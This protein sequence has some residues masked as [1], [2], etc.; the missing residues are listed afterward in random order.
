MPVILRVSY[1]LRLICSSNSS[2]VCELHWNSG[3]FWRE[4]RSLTCSTVPFGIIGTILKLFAELLLALALVSWCFGISVKSIFEEASSHCSLLN[5]PSGAAQVHL[6][7]KEKLEGNTFLHNAFPYLVLC[8]MS[9]LSAHGAS[10][11]REFHC[12]IL[13]A[14]APHS[15]GDACVQ[16]SV[17][18]TQR[19]PSLSLSS[20]IYGNELVG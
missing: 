1:Q 7:C 15:S 11:M 16:T 20:L 13:E 18:L 8:Q 2:C 17:S 3:G 10:L 19:V 9:P 12:S 5:G 4:K 14:I 6:E